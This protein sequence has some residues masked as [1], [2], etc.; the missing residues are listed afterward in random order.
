MQNRYSIPLVTVGSMCVIFD[1]ILRELSK[2]KSFHTTI[3]V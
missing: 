3:E 2:A 1:Y